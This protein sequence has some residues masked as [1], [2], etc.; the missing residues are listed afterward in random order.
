MNLT[1]EEALRRHPLNR[2]KLVAGANGL[3]RVIRSVNIIDSPDVSNWARHGD[4]LF[5]ADYLVK[6]EPDVLV[7]LLR[8]LNER[9]AAALGIRLGHFMEQIPDRVIEEANRLGFPLI[10]LPFEFA[11]SDQVNL[12][13]R[14]EIDRRTKRI[15]LTMDKQ[16][17]LIRFAIRPPGSLASQLP[18]IGESLGYPV[19]LVGAGGHLLYA[20]P[21]LSGR[22]LVSDWPW[23][24]K[25]VKQRGKLGWCYRI[26]LADGEDCCGFLLV[27]TGREKAIREEEGLFR[28][29]A[30]L[31][32]AQINHW[33]DDIETASGQR[34]AHLLERYLTRRITPELFLKQARSLLNLD[35]RLAYVCVKTCA[36]SPADPSAGRWRA[37]RRELALH[38]KLS[39]YSI[40]H[41][42]I[43][44]ALVS[45]IGIPDADP[46]NASL[47]AR[48]GQMFAE[49]LSYACDG[50][51]H[52][53]VSKAKN[54]PE[55]ILDAYLE[56]ES[57][58]EIGAGQA[59]SPRVVL[60]S[61]LELNHLFS[62]IPREVM[63]KYCI[64][65]LKPLLSKDTAYVRE[66]LET[67]EA[68]FEHE[69]QINAIAK[70]LYVHRNTVLYR[71]EK[72]S[73]LLGLNL[74]KTGDLLQ[75]KLALTFR[76]QLMNERFS[77][78]QAITDERGGLNRNL[79][80]RAGE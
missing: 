10:E 75:L 53:Y 47:P 48:L 49:V 78:D 30:D 69:G 8:K 9:R 24:I 16:K 54:E 13:I 40:H 52:C 5:M 51:W 32:A 46:G 36:E 12:I 15:L 62:F 60:Y 29:A 4:M 3:G 79:L 41:L 71:I 2:G 31:I 58:S 55:D 26:P 34:A 50:N 61:D 57:A 73:E 43:N 42:V 72:I 66:I 77:T 22:E 44:D 70:K 68:Y 7:G 1:V 45:V 35:G 37:V 33:Q 21:G 80:F 38:T 25:M 6:D 14:D 17:Q 28:Q 11:Y 64:N 27:V 63:A 74:R 23:D 59:G 56:C 20:S 19:A 76:Q 18:M 67:L 65:L 39:T